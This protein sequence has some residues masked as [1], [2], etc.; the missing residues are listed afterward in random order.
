MNDCTTWLTTDYGDCSNEGDLRHFDIDDFVQ[1]F[2]PLLWNSIFILT[3]NKSKMELLSSN[4]DIGFDWNKPF[5][6]NYSVY[7]MQKQRN[8]VFYSFYVV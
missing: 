1:D 4:K 6:G 8:C 5:I 3:S 7:L 2:D